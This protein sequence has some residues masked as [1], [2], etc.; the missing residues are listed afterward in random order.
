MIR[1]NVII[2]CLGALLG[3]IFIASACTPS[4]ERVE[5]EVTRYQVLEVPI[6]ETRLVEVT[7][8]VEVITEV[9]VEVTREVEIVLQPTPKSPPGSPNNPFQLIF[10][11]SFPK[12][13]IDVRGGFLVD[14][15]EEQTMCIQDGDLKPR[16]SNVNV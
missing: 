3:T 9:E 5:V 13:L 14:D 4:P 10:I 2:A 6:V 12:T 16:L 1:Q 11:P 8:E 15:L 7:R